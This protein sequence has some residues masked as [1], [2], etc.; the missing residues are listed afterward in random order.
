MEVPSKRKIAVATFVALLVAGVV[1][2]VAVL[3]AE[4]GLDPLGVGEMLGLIVLSDPAT[5]AN[6]EIPVRPDGLMNEPGAYKADSITFELGPGEGMEYKYRLDEGESMVYTWTASGFVRSEMHSEVDG[7]PAGT[8]EFF[9][10]REDA[11]SRHGTYTA[12]FPGIH[13]W[14]W[15]N[16]NDD[17]GITLTLQTA[18]FYSFAREY[19]DGAPPRDIEIPR[20]GAETTP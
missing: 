19:R 17:A 9:E 3:P 15:L 16:L 10:V 18:G 11:V 14:Y 12:P 5:L 13:G 7:A 20:L 6:G 8:A 4:Y 2:V 1:L